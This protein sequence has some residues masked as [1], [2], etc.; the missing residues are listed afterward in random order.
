MAAVGIT[1]DGTITGVALDYINENPDYG[2]KVARQEYLDQ[3][4]GKTDA[5]EVASISGATSSSEVLK[6]AIN[7]AIAAHPAAQQAPELQKG[8]E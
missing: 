1:G 2:M 6:R 8:A 4:V 3:F 7:K 5:E